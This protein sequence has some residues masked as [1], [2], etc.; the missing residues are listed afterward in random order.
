MPNSNS[1]D[2]LNDLVMPFEILAI[3][4]GSY[5]HSIS[6]FKGIYEE[7]IKYL[8]NSSTLE[9]TYSG[10]HWRWSVDYFTDWFWS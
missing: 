5:E 8:G 6:S 7:G 2:S 3:G 4:V 9:N 10:V 1:D